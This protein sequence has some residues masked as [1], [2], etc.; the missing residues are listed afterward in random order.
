MMAEIMSN[1]PNRNWRRV[2]HAAADAH[3]DRY[4]W[5]DGGA[6]MMTP[7]QLRDALRK[8]YIA[9]YVEGRVTGA[10]PRSTDHDPD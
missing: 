10:R 9:G 3:L 2:M 7:E 1:H 5:N 6:Y 4:P 8:A